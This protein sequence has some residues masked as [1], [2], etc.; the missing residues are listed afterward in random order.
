MSAPAFAW[1]FE[2][3]H[4]LGLTSSQLVLLLYM[5]DQANCREADGFFTGQ[6][7]LAKYT[8]LTERTIRELIPQLAA[9]GLI[10]VTATPGKPT[11]YQILRQPI[12][13][14]ATSALATA[15]SP[16]NG[17]SAPELA[18][19]P[20]RQS[21]PPNPG[22]SRQPPRK[23]ASPTPEAT[24]AD[25]YCTQEDYPKKG[26]CAPEA[27]QVLS[28]PENGTPQPEPSSSSAPP[29][30]ATT[31]GSSHSEPED[32][33]PPVDPGV[34]LAVLDDLKRSLRMRAYPPRA[35][36]MSP[37]E[38]ATAACGMRHVRP[39]YLPDEVLAALRAD[40][41]RSLA[42]RAVVS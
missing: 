36:V 37:D 39:A 7:R 32:D 12:G 25:P 27:S 22:N 15:A 14:E 41:R 19:A 8:R 5:A 38:M 23:F 26:A 13:A 2:K 42:R 11:M 35:A 17:A 16:A 1:A 21:V 10:R 28:F 30:Q 24:S 4:E 20:P 31:Y 6:P 40:A 33:N 18:S 34:A 9:L 3:G 29:T